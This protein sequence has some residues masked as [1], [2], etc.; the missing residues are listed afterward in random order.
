M[1]R[2]QTLMLVMSLLLVLGFAASE[3]AAQV[4]DGS[5]SGTVRDEQ[6]GALPG[7]MITATSD[8]LIT[9]RTAVTDA[10]GTYRLGNLPP[11][12]YT[13][14]GEL[15]GFAVYKQEGIRLRAAANFGVDIVLTI[16]ALEETITVTAESPM[17]EITRPSNLINID[18][19][20]Q[21]AIP[22]S[23]GKFWSD[24]L[25]FTPGV[26]TR[27]H[28]DG[29]G[30]QNY[31]GNASDHRDAVLLMEGFVASN[32]N[33]SNINRT[34][35]STA[36]IADTQVKI[37][38]VD[39]AAPMGYGLVINAIAKSGGNRLSGSASWTMQDIEWNADNTDGG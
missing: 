25:D 26:L 6:Q 37:G 35:L 36:A 38:G 28:N 13:L 16:G 12:E 32:Y 9:P 29:S 2:R 18:G 19:E 34:G 17:L 4:G 10:S 27:P 15:T 3:A 39:A 24:V 14:T 31:F 1:K 30:R 5:L 8:Q 7:V 21:K 22:V 11:G 23:D 33:D 20:F